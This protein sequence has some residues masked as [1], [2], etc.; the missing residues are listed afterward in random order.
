[1][2]EIDIQTI[3]R[4]GGGV[5]GIE[6]VSYPGQST[7]GVYEAA[8]RKQDELNARIDAARFYTMLG[9]PRRVERTR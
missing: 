7:Q 4:N 5:V 8:E 1:M 9:E 3:D 6:T 2:I